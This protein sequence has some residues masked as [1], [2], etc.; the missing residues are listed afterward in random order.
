MPWEYIVDLYL[1]IPIVYDWRTHGRP[2]IVYLFGGGTVVLLEA[3]EGPI[4]RT[5]VWHGVANWLVSLAG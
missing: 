2:H 3:L 1:L 5:A 4:G